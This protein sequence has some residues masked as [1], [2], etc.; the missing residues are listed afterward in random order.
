MQESLNVSAGMSCELARAEL[1]SGAALLDVV[2]A[3]VGDG[4][5]DDDK[6]SQMKDD[7]HLR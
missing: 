1:L 4:N 2:G 5:V 7:M 3:S 6:C